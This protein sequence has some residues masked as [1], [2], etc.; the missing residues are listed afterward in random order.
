MKRIYRMA[1]EVDEVGKCRRRT[2]ATVSTTI[3][4]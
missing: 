4:N 1:T 3:T 2:T